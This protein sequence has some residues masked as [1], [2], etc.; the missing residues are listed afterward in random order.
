MVSY[1]PSTLFTLLKVDKHLQENSPVGVKRWFEKFE[2]KV[3][4]IGED[5]YNYYLITNSSSAIQDVPNYTNVENG[6]G[7]VSSRVSKSLRLTISERTRKKVIEKYPEY[8][9]ILDPNR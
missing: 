9:F 5:L 4:A 2:F 3:T 7:L 8:N 6:M 1:A